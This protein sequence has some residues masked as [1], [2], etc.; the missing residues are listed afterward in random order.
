MG[1][2][3]TEPPAVIRRISMTSEPPK[4]K[5]NS[6]QDLKAFEELPA[7]TKEWVMLKDQAEKSSG[8]EREVTDKLIGEKAKL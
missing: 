5:R 7:E 2:A 4:T 6:D 1:A 3:V 8:R